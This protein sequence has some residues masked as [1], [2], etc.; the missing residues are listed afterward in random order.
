M[1]SIT[2]V[3]SKS[4]FSPSVFAPSFTKPCVGT[5]ELSGIAPNEKMEMLMYQVS[6]MYITAKA[7]FVKLK[8]CRYYVMS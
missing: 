6:G 1:V 4:A 5:S 3:I 8:Q 2:A 7:A